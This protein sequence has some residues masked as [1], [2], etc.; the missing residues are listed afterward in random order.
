ML[1]A[2]NVPRPLPL[3]VPAV[4]LAVLLAGCGTARPP[5]ASWSQPS[6]APSSAA[7]SPSSSPSSSRA[8]SPSPTPVVVPAGVTVG[9]AVFDRQAGVFTAQQ[10]QT[11]QFRSASLVKLL[12][13]LDFLWNRGPGYAVPAA[14]RGRLDVMLRSSDDDAASYYW[15]ADGRDQI[16][17]RMVGRLGLQNTAPPSAAGRTGWGTTGLSA[18]DVVRVY[19]YLLDSAPAPVRDYV[20]GNL[21]Q[22]TPC[23]TDRYHQA[24]GIPSAFA[25]P[26]AAKQG[27]HGFGDTPVDPCSGTGG[28]ALTVPADSRILNGAVLHT[29]GTV[30]AGDRTI[31]V[32]LTQSPT[33]TTFAKATA[34]L[35]RLVRSLPVPGGVLA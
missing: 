34:L 31:V 16:V 35:T 17:T 30:G 12:I 29:T 9:Y 10:H 25:R 27:W 3:A 19:R 4:L 23:G 18:A 15:N 26:W 32:V 14:D 22:S 13:A 5:V 28:A 33:G 24:F 11:T 21:H 6:D 1:L 2:M 7:P 8:A 20:I